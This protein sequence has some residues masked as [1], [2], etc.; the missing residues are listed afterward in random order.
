MLQA[1][2]STDW[3]KVDIDALRQHLIDMDNVV[4]HANVSTTHSDSAVVFDVSGD[5]PARESIRRMVSAQASMPPQD[6]S[7]SYKAAITDQGARLTVVTGD[8]GAV[9]KLMAL[10][11]FGLVSQGPHHQIHHNMI[12]RGQF[13]H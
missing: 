6:P 7:W 2:A 3:S 11:Y 8:P 9:V 5:G 4:L 12:A 1:D 10:G 13:P